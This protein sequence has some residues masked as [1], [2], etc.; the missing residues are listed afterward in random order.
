VHEYNGRG[1]KGLK[2][3]LKSSQALSCFDYEIHTA[4]DGLQIVHPF[5]KYVIVDVSRLETENQKNAEKLKAAI[6]EAVEILKGDKP[7]KAEIQSPTKTP[8][9]FCDGRT[10][11]YEVMYRPTSAVAAETLFSLSAKILKIAT[12]CGAFG[13]WTPDIATGEP[14]FKEQV[15]LGWKG[16]DPTDPAV[17]DGA[18][19]HYLKTIPDW[20]MEF[21]KNNYSMFYPKGHP[22]ES[23]DEHAMGLLGARME[24]ALQ[25]EIEAH[26]GR[27]MD[28]IFRGRVAPQSIDH[29]DVNMYLTAKSDETVWGLNTVAKSS[30]EQMILASKKWSDEYHPDVLGRDETWSDMG[31]PMMKMQTIEEVTMNLEKLKSKLMMK[32]AT[33]QAAELDLFVQGQPGREVWATSPAFHFVENK[34]HVEMHD[35]PVSMSVPKKD[36]YGWAFNGTWNTGHADEWTAGMHCGDGRA[37]QHGLGGIGDGIGR[38]LEVMV[39]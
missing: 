37:V 39:N 35:Y 25:T 4:R 26:N 15:G 11:L 19:G 32:F 5:A 7:S 8:P 16:L 33:N 27:S 13:G 29:V 28:E 1:K 31:E 24:M 18:D 38:S 30:I 14:K 6:R 23:I 12:L 2:I 10:K 20:K 36:V 21:V 34:T 22:E 9:I 17:V 3:V